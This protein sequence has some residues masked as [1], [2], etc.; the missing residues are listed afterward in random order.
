MSLYVNEWKKR[1]FL[2][3]RY[4][5]SLLYVTNIPGDIMADYS[6]EES[7]EAKELIPKYFDLFIDPNSCNQIFWIYE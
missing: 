2:D 3:D 7:I 4:S 5:Y 1:N 6:E